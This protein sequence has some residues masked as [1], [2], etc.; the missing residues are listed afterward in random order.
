MLTYGHIL[1]E[2]NKSDRWGINEQPEDPEEVARVLSQL[3]VKTLEMKKPDTLII[4]FDRGLTEDEA[5]TLRKAVNLFPEHDE[6]PFAPNKP[7]IEA[8]CWW[9]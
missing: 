4:T 7:K 9:D 8:F 1:T 6:D 2:L 3:P 5:D